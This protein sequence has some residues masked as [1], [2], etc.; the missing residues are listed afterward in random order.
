MNFPRENLSET[1]FAFS[2]DIFRLDG[3]DCFDVFKGK[4]IVSSVR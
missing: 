1:T 4:E 2:P 3:Q